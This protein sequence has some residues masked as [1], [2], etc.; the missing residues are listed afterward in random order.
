MIAQSARL[1][2]D[3]Q[4]LRCFSLS[5]ELHLQSVRFMGQHVSARGAGAQLEAGPL[6]LVQ[7][8]QVWQG[9]RLPTAGTSPP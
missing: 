4:D 9:D 6:H 5:T 8:Y 1:L 7:A 3:V 2:G